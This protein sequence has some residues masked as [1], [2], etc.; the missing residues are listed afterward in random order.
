MSYEIVE[1]SSGFWV[2]NEN[3]ACDGPFDTDKEA[4]EVLEVCYGKTVEKVDKTI[5]KRFRRLSDNEKIER[6]DFHSLDNGITLMPLASDESI[7]QTPTE[8]NTF[9]RSFWRLDNQ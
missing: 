6:G 1:R 5:V 8:F 9:C 4:A 3:G 7:G 2:V